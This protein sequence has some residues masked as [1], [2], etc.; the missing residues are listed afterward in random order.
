LLKSSQ[1]RSFQNKIYNYYQKN[2]R[3]LPWRKTRNPYKI[4]IAEIMLQQTQVE[5]VLGKYKEFLASFPDFDSLA[6]APLRKLLRLW[7]GL[8]YN[9]RAL[10]LQSL[11]KQVIAEHQGKLPSD[12]K[13]LLTLPG[14]G[15]YTA[16]A[17][18]AFAY[19][20]PEIFMDTNIR[21][22]FINEFF[23]DREGIRDDE[24][25]PLV[26]QTLDRRNPR[27][28]YNALMDYGSMLKH[29]HINLNRK[30]AHYVHQKSFINSRRQ[31]RGM[32]L[33]V[34][35]NEPVLT[36]AQIGEKTGIE[37]NKIKINLDCLCKEGFINK[38]GNLFFI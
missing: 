3:T 5:R 27:L 1:I 10:A 18:A 28:W 11:A 20:I 30:S 35:V 32:I 16:G 17:V 2:G 8:G 33:K 34:F 36:V 23:F 22:V 31:I 29:G 26:K 25:F 12:P 14:I 9:R 7:S 24:I 21:R 6:H 15:K 37:K 4:L 13:E 19:N 38:R